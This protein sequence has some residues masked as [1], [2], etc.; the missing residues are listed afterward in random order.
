MLFRSDVL[1]RS[2]LQLITTIPVGLHL[3]GESSNWQQ[4]IEAGYL[5]GCRR[6]DGAIGGY[7]GCP[8]TGSERVGNIDTLKMNHWFSNNQIRTGVDQH[9]LELCAQQARQLFS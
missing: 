5:A 4:K 9:Q 2:V 8:F 3:H 1:T 7:G 6:F